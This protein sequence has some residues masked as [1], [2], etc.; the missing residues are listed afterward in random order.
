MRNAYHATVKL[1]VTGKTKYFAVNFR[2]K[3]NNR[4]TNIIYSEGI[5]HKVRSE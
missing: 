2:M 4:P 3:K 5:Q 1:Q